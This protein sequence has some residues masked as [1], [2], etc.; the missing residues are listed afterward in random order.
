[1]SLFVDNV[2]LL[3]QLITVENG[4]LPWKHNGRT[5]TNPRVS[6]LTPNIIT[7]LQVNDFKRCKNKIMFD[8]VI[9]GIQISVISFPNIERVSET[10]LL[11][12]NRRESIT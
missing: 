8:H 2:R 7:D 12:V 1:M 9:Q 11:Y 10:L 3:S 6:E 4:I 5:N